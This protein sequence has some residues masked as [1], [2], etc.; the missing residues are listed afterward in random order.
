MDAMYR[1][2]CEAISDAPMQA[3][4]LPEPLLD[5]VAVSDWLGVPA[6]WVYE[7][8]RRPGAIP[9]RRIGRYV[10]F[11]LDEIRDWVD[12]GCP[13]EQGLPSYSTT[14]LRGRY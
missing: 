4:T 7:R 12:A 5:V 2:E 6:S 9:H 11:S 13:S 10:R 14:S 3:S 1:R 8:T